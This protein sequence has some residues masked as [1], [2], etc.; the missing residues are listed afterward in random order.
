MA[1]EKAIEKLANL[2]QVAM[3]SS[4]PITLS[5]SF[6]VFNGIIEYRQQQAV[7]AYKEEQERERKANDNGDLVT[8]KE[9]KGLLHISD[10]T[11]WRYAKDGLLAR[12]QVGGKVYYSRTEISKMLEGVTTPGSL[13]EPQAPDVCPRSGERNFMKV[14]ADRRKEAKR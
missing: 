5:L 4:Q 10:A 7:E 2:M 11:L 12:R 13:A 6:E 14:W 3:E 8:P 9:A 1:N